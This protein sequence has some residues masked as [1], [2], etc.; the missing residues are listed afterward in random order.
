MNVVF[1]AVDD[2]NNDLGSFGHPVVKSPHIDRLASRGVRF[3][4]AYCQYPIC[5]HS[6]TSVMTGL[7]PDTI[8]LTDNSMLNTVH[9]R[10]NMPDV[11]TLPQLFRQHGYVAARVGKIYHYGVP[12][13]IG[14]ESALD[15]KE[16]WDLALYPRGVDKDEEELLKNCTPRRKTGTALAWH[17][18]DADPLEHTDGKV[19]TEAIR[20][21][22]EYKER[23]FFLAVG[24][25]RP[26]VPAI[27]PRKYFELYPAGQVRL[28][29]EPPEHLAG[30]PKA[31]FDP[32]FDRLRFDPDEQADCLADFK[33]AYYAT[34]SFVDEQIGR[35][36]DAVERLGLAERTVIVLWSDH[37]WLLG[38]H[39]QWEKRSLFEPSARTP[40]VISAPGRKGNGRAASR[41]V[42][43]IDIYPTV[44][45]LCGLPPP[46]RLEGKSLTPLLDTPDTA[47]NRPAYTQVSRRGIEG[48]SVCDE[49]WRYTEWNG[50]EKGI[51][52]YDHHRD[53]NEYRNLAGD[54]SHREVAARMRQILRRPLH[55]R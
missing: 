28:P 3:T 29:V 6:R 24:F 53:P 39:R 30:I 26:H 20:L 51:E 21:M 48:R 42:E 50:G 37:G 35:V 27:A 40:L 52:L 12:R 11:V 17:A 2:L 1:I 31:A 43:F 16:S 34:V 15:D 7:R 18:S 41:V 45:D 10:S 13:E 38:E 32:Q 47:W 46:D 55:G 22:E 19:A 14:T 4:R 25:Y 8:G 23:P 5:N 54:P 9:F 36:V 44:A 33:R 49:R